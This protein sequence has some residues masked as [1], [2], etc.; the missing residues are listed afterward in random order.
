MRA[1]V[2]SG[3]THEAIDPVRYTA[4]RSS[5]RQGHA[6]AEALAR[7]GAETTLVSGPTNLADPA[8]VRVVRVESAEDMLAACRGALPVEVAVCAAAVADWKVASAK[9]QKLK[10]DGDLPR[11]ELAQNPDILTAGISI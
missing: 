7:L 8:G 10:K 6:I 2:T 5:G 3:P 1:L 11:L 4:N 9:S